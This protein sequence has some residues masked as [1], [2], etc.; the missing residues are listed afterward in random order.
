VVPF[1]ERREFTDDEGL[2]TL[3][4]Q[5]A[6]LAGLAAEVETHV[7]LV[8]W[9][10]V[11]LDALLNDRGKFKNWLDQRRREA[12]SFLMGVYEVRNQLVHDANPFG[13][14]DAYRLR[15]LYERYRVVI[16]PVVAELLQLVGTDLAMPLKHAWA[17][18]RARFGELIAHQGN[19]K[20]GGPVDTQAILVCFV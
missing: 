4:E 11:A 8:A 9:Q 13:F 7:P 15:D 6:D 10:L 17:L 2:R 14:D 16:N 5:R 1:F 3:L 20:K 19:G 18:L 12:A